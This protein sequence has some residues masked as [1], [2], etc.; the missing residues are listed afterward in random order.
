[1]IGGLS[2]LNERRY[3]PVF[4]VKLLSGQVDAGPGIMKRLSILPVCEIW[5]VNVFAGNGTVVD[6]FVIAITEIR[7]FYNRQQSSFRKSLQV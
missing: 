1:M 6:F 5:I 2:L 3:V 7:C 4:L